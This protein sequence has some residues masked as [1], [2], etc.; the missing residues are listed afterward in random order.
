[1]ASANSL[2]LPKRMADAYFSGTFKMLLVSAVPTETELDTF[3]FRNDIVTE[4]GASGTYA[5]GGSTVTCSVGAVDTANNRVAVTFGNPAA[6]TGATISAVGAWIYKSVGTAATDELVTF[7]DFGG[8][9]TSTA[10]SFTVTL[11]TPL[12]VNR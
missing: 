8:T 11:S 6:W 10:G 4:V 12:Y 1:M 2:F 3:D 7:V 5:A 9:V